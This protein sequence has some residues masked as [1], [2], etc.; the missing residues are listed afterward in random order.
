MRHILHAITATLLWVIFVVY[1]RMVAQTPM[2]AD[3]RLSLMTLIALVVVAALFM[4]MWVYHN[5]R[6]FNRFHRRAHRRTVE[7][8]PRRDFLGRWLVAEDPDELAGAAF[9]DIDVRT[10][11]VP[12][13]AVEE[14]IFRVQRPLNHV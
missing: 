8:M 5:I 12:G 9:I 2:S 4:V 13:I 1:W 14:K 10:S 3:T 7:R 11:S 6:I